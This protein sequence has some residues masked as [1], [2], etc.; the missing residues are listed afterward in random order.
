M[1]GGVKTTKIRSIQFAY[2][3]LFENML[4]GMLLNVLLQHVLS[5]AVAQNE[6][7]IVAERESFIFEILLLKRL[8]FEIHKK[9]RFVQF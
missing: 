2:V 7:R 1:E 4:I 9:I 6:V 3:F 8:F 5:A